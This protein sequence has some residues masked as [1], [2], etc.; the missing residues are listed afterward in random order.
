MNKLVAG[1]LFAMALPIRLNRIQEPSQVVFDEVHFG[2]FANH[3][4]Q[5]KFFFDVH[6]PLAKLLIA[7]TGSLA[8]YD[9]Q[10]DFSQIG[11]NYLQHDIPYTAMRAACAILGAFTVPMA[12]LTIRDGGHSLPAALM[13]AVAVCYENSMVTNNRLIMLDSYLLF[14]TA[15]TILCWNRFYSANRNRP[16]QA[17]WWLWLTLTG[18]GL[19]MTVSCKWVGLFLI[20]TI[21]SS[22]VKDLWHL[23]GNLSVSKSH[24]IRHFMARAMCL[25]VLPVLIYVFTFY[26]HFI[27]LR[28]SGEGDVHMSAAF[29]HS[30]VGNRVPDSPI[31]IAYGSRVT[32]RHLASKG[33]YLHSHPS[34]YPEGSKQQQIT[35]YPYR[36]ENNWWIIRQM[37]STLDLQNEGDMLGSDNNTWVKWVRHGDI[38]RLD[39]ASTAPRR[40]HSH[41]IAAPVS[42][43]EYQKEV[44]A[45]GFPDYEGDA[46]DY[47]RVEIESGAPTKEAGER[48]QTLRSQFR[49]VH[50]MQ[51]CAL[52]S[53]D[54]KLP[55]WGFGQQQ[56]TCMQNSKKPKALWMI[57]ET[58]NSFLPQD[59]KYVNYLVPNFWE[60]FVELHKVMWT[61]NSKLTEPHPYQS[62]PS[63]WP[64]LQSGIS[65]WASDHKHVYFL[66]NPLI[67]WGSLVGVFTFLILSLFFQIRHKRGLPDRYP[68]K[69]E[70]FENAAGFY[71]AGW[72]FHYL[73]F[74]LMGRQLFLHHYLPALYFATLVLAVGFDLA[75]TRLP[76]GGRLLVTLGVCVA[77]IATFHSFAPITYGTDWTKEACEAAHWL[78]TWDFGC[79]RYGN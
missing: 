46:N 44:S 7:A 33:G 35:L 75:L 2:G 71:A 16:F 76:E 13:A 5:R 78:P 65:F 39:H 66:G 57:E 24:F 68:G 61:A 42:D 38:I 74:F 64:V 21:G 70:F 51:N 28:Y 6:P 52:F 63:S 31:D 8:G 62:R 69:R 10:F 60:K 12:F 22:T 56:V 25:I 54:V 40:L 59:T 30:L 36:D 49:L 27:V 3:Y 48:L 23:W 37:N 15:L 67:Y 73:P 47:W 43:V 45:Y 32:L 58:Y 29:Q 34:N 50:L 53:S 41:D 20:A 55:E 17:S 4:I 18:A 11:N 72:A 77:I 19:G 14:F 79:E 1:L 26:I 9:G